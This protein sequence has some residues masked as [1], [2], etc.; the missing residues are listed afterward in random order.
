MLAEFY[1]PAELA[2]VFAQHGS[3]EVLT[4]LIVN[5]CFDGLAVR[6]GTV[7]LCRL[8]DCL[9]GK[10]DFPLDLFG[11]GPGFFFCG[12]AILFP[13]LRPAEMF[14]AVA[15]LVKL[16]SGMLA[17]ERVAEKDVMMGALMDPPAARNMAHP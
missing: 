17:I 11:T 6:A 10:F 4:L 8:S 16:F 14:P 15:A 7:G 3:V 2:A 9:I 5:E 13:A 1:E 12:A